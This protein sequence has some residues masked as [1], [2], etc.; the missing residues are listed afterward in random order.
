M[1]D[2]IILRIMHSG[3]PQSLSPEELALET[4]PVTRA[5]VSPAIRAWVRYPDGPLQVE[6]EAVAWSASALAIRW[7]V[8]DVVH[9]AWVWSSPVERL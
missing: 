1:N 6:G 2:S 5:P 7:P 8:G 4:M 3:P 9:K